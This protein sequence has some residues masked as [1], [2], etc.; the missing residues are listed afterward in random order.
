MMAAAANSL[1]ESTGLG[2]DGGGGADEGSNA[3][4]AD[5]D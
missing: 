1:G 2:C 4:G 3:E 5:E